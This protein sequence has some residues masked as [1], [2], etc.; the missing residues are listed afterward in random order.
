MSLVKVYAGACGMPTGHPM[1]ACACISRAA[2]R[3]ALTWRPRTSHHLRDVAMTRFLSE[4]SCGPFPHRGHVRAS[5]AGEIKH[6]W[7]GQR[8][9]AERMPDHGLL[10]LA[11]TY[12][13]MWGQHLTF[14]AQRSLGEAMSLANG[15]PLGHGPSGFGGSTA[16]RSSAISS[17]GK[18]ATFIENRTPAALLPAPD[19]PGS[20]AVNEVQVFIQCHRM[21]VFGKCSKTLCRAPTRHPI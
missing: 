11:C 13:T 14:S 15:L 12:P 8:A 10:G 18:G 19:K 16:R 20:I 7:G 3:R 6:R 1:H 4:C 9:T 21:Q 17:G 5:A 2:K